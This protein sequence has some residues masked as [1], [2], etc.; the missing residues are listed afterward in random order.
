MVLK[1]CLEPNSD[2]AVLSAE[3]Q[4]DWTN[5]KNVIHEKVLA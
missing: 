4:N 1:F 5:K 3:F 2:T